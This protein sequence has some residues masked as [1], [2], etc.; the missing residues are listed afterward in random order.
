MQRRDT[1]ARKTL[2][3]LPFKAVLFDKDDTLI[4]LAAF[5]A[6]PVRK[7]AEFLLHELGASQDEALLLAL[8][9]A[10]GLQDGRLIPESPLASGTNA[11]V[12]LAWKSVL[13]KRNIPI[14]LDDDVIPKVLE[15][16]CIR[17]GEVVPRA[18]FTGLLQELKRQRL[19]L[20]VA[21]SDSFSSVMHCLDALH[22]TGYFDAV[23]TADR[24]QHPKPH[25]QMAQQFSQLTGVPAE[26]I[27]MVGDTASDMLFAHNSGM[28][29]VFYS[30]EGRPAALPLGAAYCI[31]QPEE[32]LRL[33][34]LE[35]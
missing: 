19:P 14:P 32:L 34:T 23:L 22:L 24:V 9:Q 21:T 30:P 16:S 15:Q 33:S 13:K 17:F 8:L 28:I 6:K 18:D 10:A 25:P 4:D 7:T 29:G 11:Q 2:D 12:W 31:E 5:W 26:Q 27:A 20:G 35:A 1:S 3:T